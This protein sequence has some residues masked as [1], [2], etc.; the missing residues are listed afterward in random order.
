M[1]NQRFLLIL[2]SGM[3][4]FSCNNDDK[5]KLFTKLSK[6]KTGIDFR[7]LL[8]ENDSSFNILKYPYF[9][10]G[11]G[12]A[13]GDLNNDGLPDLVFTGNMVKNRLYINKGNFKFEDVTQQSHIAD[14]EGWCTGVTLV[15]INNDGWLDIYICRSGFDN[16]ELRKNL[17]F[18]NNH[19]LT[20]T[21]E[22]AQYGLDNAGYS[23]QASFFDYDKDGDLDML[24][25]N[26]STPDYSK[27][28][29]SYPEQLNQQASPLFENKL[30]RNDN[31]HFTDVTKEAGIQSDLLT[32]SLGVSTADI[33]MDGWPDIYISNDFND[34]D[35]FYI[36][37]HD[38]TFSPQ[39]KNKVDHTSLY[40]M[41]CD[42]ADYNND[43][44]PDI[45][46][47]DMLPE[48]NHEIKMHF[49][50]DNYDAY[51]TLFNK[52]YYY[53]YMRNSLQKNNG[54]G[55][56]SEIAQ[57]AGIS[58]TDWSWSPLF[59][60]FDND[61][62]KDLFISN[63]YERDNTN[64]EYVK[65]SYNENLRLQ[66]GGNPMNLEDYISKMP[67]IKI[68]HYMYQNE[69]NDHFE[70]KINDWGLSDTSVANGAV[71]ADLDND[72]DL[73]LVTNNANSYASVYRNNGE[74][75]LKNNFLRLQLHGSKQNA[76]GFGAKV[77]A[78]N[79]G[80]VFYYEQLPVRG[81]Q[82]SVDMTMHIGLGNIMQLDSLRIIWPTDETQLLLNVK[83]DHTLQLN[84]SDAKGKY[85]YL[86]KTTIPF[87]TSDSVTLNYTHKE[88]YVNDFARQ[89]LLPHFYSHEGP[90]IC[91]ADINGD[92]LE[93]IF[94]GGSKGNA[95]AV[96]IQQPN[97]TFKKIAEPAIEA[98]SLSEDADA[99]FFDANGDNKPDLFIASGGYDDYDENDSLLQDRLY[100]NDG[101]GK[102]IKQQ[103][104]LPANHGSKSCVRAYDIDGDGDL[105]LFIG[106]KVVPGKWPQS[107]ASS[108]YINDGHGKFTDE[109][110]KW[111]ASLKNIGIV[112][113]AVWADVNHDN[114]KDLIVVGEWMSP[115][116]FINDHK[117]LTASPLNKQ[118]DSLKGWWNTIVADDIDKDGN[119]DLILGNYGLNSQLKASDKKQVQLYATDI[120]DNGTI[121]PII[122]SY[123]GDKSFPF[124]MMDDL[125]MQVPSL[126]KKFLDYNTYAD[127]TIS[128]II[129]LQKL[130]AIKPLQANTFS[131]I[132]L[133]NTGNG[134]IVEQLP[135]EAQYAPVF[136]VCCV[137]VN[138]DG[139]DD[140]LLFGNNNYN[141]IRIGRLD[142]NHG[143]LLL[144]NGK[145]KFSYV[146]QYESGFDVRGDVRST[147]MMNNK[148]FIGV[149]D[150]PVQV[151]QLH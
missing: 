94:I 16:P 17:L 145:G 116:I 111:N 78:Y 151:Y 33:N 109:T 55:S 132:I 63:G 150:K 64:I 149:N 42:V 89:L 12:V 80:N 129:P 124:I 106:G 146:P 101:H 88:N 50:A 3:L 36:N 15:D 52:G 34:Q 66:Q 102:F 6:N 69:G 19:D 38:G 46:V 139:Y 107:C 144:N 90:C 60:D 125:N 108:I 57:L 84:I 40:S 25:I 148:L 87:F 20:F 68:N 51:Q 103:N 31:G 47:L 93:D 54:D 7:N 18:I 121:D 82:S 14:K 10:N 59:A 5:S 35:Y 53:Q 24:L 29:S 23:T 22:A 21:E 119:I 77:Y 27:N 133:K 32:F 67:P 49:G 9:Y 142:A 39:L 61:G 143:I 13:V 56:F 96:F 105:D 4:L 91:S 28:M 138:K 41:G 97:H 62:K 11:G 71:Y 81:Y 140:L 73:D 26:Q 99:I 1:L 2:L 75:L 130:A 110:N 83:A 131:T 127:A 115:T 100:I 118:L 126:R 95:G 43:G 112:T 117:T 135:V 147:L 120:D 44:L 136:T 74:T 45:C 92:G 70:N 72:G 8:I 65:F 79:K 86:T 104:A 98:D 30:Y 114:I 141:R 85:N 128:D 123:Y 58:N 76:F 134:F 48:N 137:D 122:T 113:D 37:N